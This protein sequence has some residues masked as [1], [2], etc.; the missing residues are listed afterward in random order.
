LGRGIAVS[1]ARIAGRF[2]LTGEKFAATVRRLGR[3]NAKRGQTCA[4]I[5][6]IDG[7]E[8]RSRSFA[9]T[10]MKSEAIAGRFLVTAENSGKID[11]IYVATGATSGET[12]AMRATK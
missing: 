5:V 1:C 6:R 4:S 11:A 9:P 3:T 7:K 2:V 12:A 10:A 8:L